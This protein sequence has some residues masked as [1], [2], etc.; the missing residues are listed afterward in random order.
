[1]V[2]KSCYKVKPLRVL[3]LTRYGEVGASSRLRFL[4]YYPAL[5]AAG[6][7]VEW[8]PLFNDTALR[9]RYR[10]GRY[11]LGAALLAF[12][13][14]LQAMRKR[15]HFDVVW[16]E[17]EALPYLPLWLE[18]ALLSGVPYVLD[19]DDAVFHNYDHHKFALVRWFLGSRLDHL[20]AKA[21]LVVC[22]NP[23][24]SDR[25]IRVGAS[26]VEMLPTVVDL[27]RYRFSTFTHSTKGDGVLRIIWIGS[28]STVRYLQILERPLQQLCR[29]VNF[30]L[31]VIGA[32]FQMPGIQVECMPWTESTEVESIAAGHIGVMP[33]RDSPWERGKCGYKL[34]QYMACGLP[35]VA[36]PVGVNTDLVETGVNGYL[37]SNYEEWLSALELLL[38]QA[39]LRQSMGSSGRT[40]VE[41]K[42]CIQRT[43]P[44]MAELLKT[45]A[46]D[47]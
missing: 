11:R 33:L 35:V 19:Y 4:Q 7:H 12:S 6:I 47:D 26:W 31:R 23:Y 20:M 30:V 42:Y 29:H 34:I 27:A 46:K 18:S 16:I 10:R 44:R 8:Q 5:Q 45:A 2:V 32:E 3:A 37:A 21:A 1:V 38:S 39:H 17:K 36:S 28:P 43:G 14:R 25:A 15:G 22:G 24:L 40:K 41:A 9:A 13:A